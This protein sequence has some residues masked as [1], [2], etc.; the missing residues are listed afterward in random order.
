MYLIFRN[1]RLAAESGY[2]EPTQQKLHPATAQKLAEATN[3]L[4]QPASSYL[5]IVFLYVVT[6]LGLT[7]LVLQTRWDQPRLIMVYT[8]LLLMVIW[9]AF[10]AY[11]HHRGNTG[12]YLY[13]FLVVFMLGSSLL[14]TTKKSIRQFP[15]LKKNIA[16]DAYYGYTPDWE[17]YLRLSAWCADSLPPNSLVACR[18]AP[19]SFVYG[20]GKEFFP[21]YTV[22]AIDTVTN[23]SNA[24]SVL[25][26]FKQNNVTHVLLASLRRNPNKPDGYIINTLHRM[27]EP[28][29]RKYP[30]K[31]KLVKT[32]GSS[33]AAHLYEVRY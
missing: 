12:L 28:I 27:L 24:D 13:F 33:E 8:P 17:N 16:G 1:R 11:F 31:L 32:V 15:V 5:L 30:Q 4:R 18:K 2:V 14:T 6:M 25:T 19:M 3:T 26:Y 9:Y 22:V 21:V 20:K 29:S 10:Y 23:L 7:F